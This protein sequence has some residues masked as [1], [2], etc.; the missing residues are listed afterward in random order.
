MILLILTDGVFN[1][2]NESVEAIVEAS[3]HPL[4]IIIVGTGD[5]DFSGADT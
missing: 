2:M 3:N 1:D 5:A 4:S